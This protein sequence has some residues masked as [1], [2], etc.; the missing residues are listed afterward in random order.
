MS[1]FFT[2]G[3]NRQR[4]AKVNFISTRVK[5]IQKLPVSEYRRAVRLSRIHKKNKC[6]PGEQLT[7]VK[8]EGLRLTESW[9]GHMIGFEKSYDQKA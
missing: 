9:A 4:E 5:Y 7:T 2:Q 3:Y 6:E 8:D 1:N